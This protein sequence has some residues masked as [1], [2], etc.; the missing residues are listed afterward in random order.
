MGVILP[1]LRVLTHMETHF[2]TVCGCKP[3][4]VPV[5]L[6][7]ALSAS[8]LSVHTTG[9][10][11]MLHIAK[12]SLGF[13]L[14]DC[15]IP[16]PAAAPVLSL[17]RHGLQQEKGFGGAGAML[18]PVACSRQCPCQTLGLVE[19]VMTQVAAETP[20]CV[21]EWGCQLRAPRSHRQPH[22]TLEIFTIYLPSLPSLLCG[23]GSYLPSIRP[24]E[25]LFECA[26]K[27]SLA[28]PESPA[29]RGRAPCTW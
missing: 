14:P 22:W 26:I 17:P 25:Q 9:L 1:A 8:V 21:T 24:P 4:A 20:A 10:Q 28:V 19:C 6:P 7:C 2:G 18:P 15:G 27:R 3:A 16:C 11:L 5:P 29:S 23:G 13:A 12:L